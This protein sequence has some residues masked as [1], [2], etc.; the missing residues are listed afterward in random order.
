MNVVN[1]FLLVGQFILLQTFVELSIV[2]VGVSFEI[3]ILKTRVRV[4]YDARNFVFFSI[5]M[6]FDLQ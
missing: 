3:P 4:P 6:K 1:Y 5:E 2:G